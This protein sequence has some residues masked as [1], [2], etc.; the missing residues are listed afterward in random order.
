MSMLLRF[1]LWCGLALTVASAPAGAQDYPTRPVR[2]VVTYAPGV[3]TDIV[4]RVI[5][6][7]MA[8]LLGQ[9]VIVENKPGA[10][11]V[12]GFE[13]V[14]RGSPADGYTV[15][16]SIVPGLASL[17]LL[18][19][20]LKFD[21][22]KDLPPV[23]DLT[24]S[25][26]VFG[27]SNKFPWR[28]MAELVAAA[29]ANPGKL[30]YGVAS[31]LTRIMMEGFVKDFNI[32]AVQVGFTGGGPWNT[33]LGQGTVEMGFIAEGAAVG[34]AERV[35][36]LA[37]TGEDRSKHFPN[38]PTFRELGY[39]DYRGLA[40]SLNVRA[41]TPRVAIEKL[42]AAAAAVMKQPEVRTRLQGAG[43]DIIAD[44]SM[45]AASRRLADQAR[46]FAQVARATGTK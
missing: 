22:L 8:K 1:A 26:L 3:V 46:F 33:A 43:F 39:P 13:H 38:A 42:H 25:R 18:T 9:P 11:T 41:G 21:P 31:S 29:R 10:D 20:D 6:P 4:A 5:A 35:T 27:S 14:A 19:K 16:V 2:F 28:T 40:I 36:A 37:V 17:P 12:I 34:L 15:V 45:E 7:E 30:N 32:D 44:S 23:I 24:D